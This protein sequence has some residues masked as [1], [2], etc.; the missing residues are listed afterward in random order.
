[1]RYSI[2]PLALVAALAAAS[3]SA[4]MPEELTGAEIKEWIDG[5]TIVG[6]WAGTHYRQFFQTDGITAF[7][8]KGAAIELGRWWVTETEFCAL[9][10]NGGE[11]CYRIVRDGDLLIWQTMSVWQRNFTAEVLVGNQLESE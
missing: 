6:V 1:M 9:Y 11:V 7:A 5:N 8:V 3:P 4:A 2:A 10:L